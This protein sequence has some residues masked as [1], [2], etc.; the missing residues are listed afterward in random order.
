MRFNIGIALL[1]IAACFGVVWLHFG[2]NCQFAVVSVPLFMILSV[3]LSARKLGDRG[4]LIKRLAR[5]YLPFAAWGIIYFT[6]GTI[7][8]RRIDFANLIL[9]LTI[10]VPACPPLYFIFLLIVSTLILQRVEYV[11]GGGNTCGISRYMFLFTIFRAELC[12]V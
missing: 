3:Y 9:Q 4:G 5:L 7:L 11:R 10:G 12:Y 8:E 1:K 6:L 2:A